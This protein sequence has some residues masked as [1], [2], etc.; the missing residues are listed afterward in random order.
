MGSAGGDGV[1]RGPGLCTRFAK[2][3]SRRINA[4]AFQTGVIRRG[5]RLLPMKASQ[6]RGLL[7]TLRS[8]WTA[9][10][11]SLPPVVRSLLVSAGLLTL[12]LIWES[13][14]GHLGYVAEHAFTSPEI[15]A[16]WT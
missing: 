10:A 16:R 15:R 5:A 11:K 7:P 14:F 3:T 4:M 2:R 13:A 1:C 12:Y 6:A 8:W 9:E